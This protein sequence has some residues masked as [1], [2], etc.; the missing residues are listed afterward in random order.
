MEGEGP[1]EPPSPRL[2]DVWSDNDESR[3]MSRSYFQLPSIPGKAAKIQNAE[4]AGGQGNTAAGKKLDANF[5][6]KQVP[7]F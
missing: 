2:D 6:A 4:D 7:D 3:K 5:V 1:L